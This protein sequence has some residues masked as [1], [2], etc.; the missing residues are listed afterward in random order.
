MNVYTRGTHTTVTEVK[1]KYDHN[2]SD[3]KGGLVVAF[4]WGRVTKRVVFKIKY[5]F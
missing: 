2:K 5:F 1:Q 3:K 4:T